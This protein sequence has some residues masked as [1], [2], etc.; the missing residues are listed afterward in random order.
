MDFQTLV[1]A[2]DP[3]AK[4]HVARLRAPVFIRRLGQSAPVNDQSPVND[5]RRAS[6]LGDF[7]ESESFVF[8]DVARVEKSGASEFVRPKR[9]VRK[10][11]TVLRAIVFCMHAR[12]NYRS[13]SFKFNSSSDCTT[14]F[15]PFR[16]CLFPFFKLRHC[17][18][19][20]IYFTKALT[21]LNFPER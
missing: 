21:K 17:C 14:M 2:D 11:F 7:R 5:H 6:H 9:A 1:L 19:Q 10:R 12:W 3:V 13:R 18:V 20:L 4:A 16:T 15:S 8:A